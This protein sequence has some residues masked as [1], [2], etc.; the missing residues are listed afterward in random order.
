MERPRV[1]GSTVHHYGAT[2]DCAL[3]SD[4]T[5]FHRVYDGVTLV[6][7]GSVDTG[8]VACRAT[9]GGGIWDGVLDCTIGL[10]RAC[11]GTHH[12]MGQTARPAHHK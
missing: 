4:R 8:T 3:L 12:G 11:A 9:C 6:A 7:A 2:C 10:D 1:R 5:W